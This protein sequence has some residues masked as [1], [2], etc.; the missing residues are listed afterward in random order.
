MSRVQPDG[1]TSLYDAVAAGMEALTSARHQ[2]RALVVISDGDDE[3]PV[4]YQ[5]PRAASKAREAIAADSVRRSEALVYA[6]GVNPL[7]GSS[8]PFDGAA[9]DRI[10]APT[11]GET[12]MVTTDAAIVTA[13]EQIGDE[14]RQQYVLGFAPAH[15]GDGTFHKVQVT[16]SGCEKCRVRARSG[17]IAGLPK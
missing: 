10:T 1:A 14:L 11:G 5:D 9:L 17:F 16:V 7:K 8:Y 4:R 13:A 2:R 12:R 6:I 15:P 3:L